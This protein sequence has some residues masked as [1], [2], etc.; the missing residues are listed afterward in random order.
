MSIIISN[1]K[2]VGKGNGKYSPSLSLSRRNP[3]NSKRVPP[4]KCKL[5]WKPRSTFKTINQIHGH[6]TYEH[7]SEDFKPYLFGLVKK[8]FGETAK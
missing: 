1:Y 5:C 6:L 7:N 3:V 2:R 8:I 4:F